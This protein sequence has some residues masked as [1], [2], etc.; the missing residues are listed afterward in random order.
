MPEDLQ[1]TEWSSIIECVEKLRKQ[2]PDSVYKKTVMEIVQDLSARYDKQI[3][4][5][6]DEYNNLSTFM[7]KQRY[8]NDV[9]RNREEGYQHSKNRLNNYLRNPEPQPYETWV[10]PLVYEFMKQNGYRYTIEFY[11]S[12]NAVLK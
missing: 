2:Y 10:T 7:E 3:Q 5:K 12:L 1:E 8:Y 11:I 6:R 9:L 4:K